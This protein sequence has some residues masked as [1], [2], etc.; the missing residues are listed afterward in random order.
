VH[1]GAAVPYPPSV[2][3]VTISF[4]CLLCHASCAATVTGLDDPVASIASRTQDTLRKS[5]A[6]LVRAGRA[7][8]GD[9]V[10]EIAAKILQQ[11]AREVLLYATCPRCGAK[12][13]EGVTAH[14]KDRRR[15]RW[16]TAAILVVLAV[17]A[18]FVRWIALVLPSA[19]LLVF[20]LMAIVHAR[21]S[22]Q[23]V[24]WL[25]MATNVATDLSFVAVVVFVPRAAPLL[26]LVPIAVML[27][28]RPAADER[29]WTEAAETI[30]F[31]EA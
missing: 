30:R 13:P 3:S 1:V 7:E 17:G 5:R 14:A 16:I 15:W 29:P 24:R 12:N 10:D 26:L 22:R 31:E 9:P 28:R 27:V 23:P 4:E 21:R 25:A 18:W 19:D 8:E 11:R 20:R 6:L 2:P